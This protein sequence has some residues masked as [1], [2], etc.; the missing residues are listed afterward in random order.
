V[1]ADPGMQRDSPA[2]DEV[3]SHGGRR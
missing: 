2:P 1:R 3:F